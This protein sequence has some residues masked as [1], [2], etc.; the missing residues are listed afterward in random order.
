MEYENQRYF[1]GREVLRHN[2]ESELVIRWPKR[3]VFEN[4]VY[5]VYNPQVSPGIRKSSV[6]WNTGLSYLFLK[7]DKGQLKLSV[8]DLL[9]QN[10]F[11]YRYTSENSIYDYQSTSLRRY[12]MLSFI[13][14]I[15]TFNPGKVGGK[16]RGFF[17]F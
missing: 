10:I 12:V 7:E 3:V 14:N 16:D 17:L 1:Q 15:R 6:R 2:T 9:N 11:V 13:Y 4:L 8:Y 5:Y